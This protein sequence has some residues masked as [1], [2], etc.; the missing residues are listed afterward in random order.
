MPFAAALSTAPQTAAAVDQV[1][2]ESRSRFSGSPDLAV[3]FFST[4]H[5]EAADRRMWAGR[6]V[7]QAVAA[8]VLLREAVTHSLWAAACARNAGADLDSVLL[9]KLRYKITSSIPVPIRKALCSEPV[10]S[11][12]KTAI[13]WMA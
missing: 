2:N 10:A 5:A 8:A 11:N 9:T 13:G 4:H 1:C 6:R 7:T 3:A 12:G